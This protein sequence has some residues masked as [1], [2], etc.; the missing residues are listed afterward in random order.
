[1]SSVYILFSFAVTNVFSFPVLTEEFC[2]LML[3]ELGHFEQSDSPKGRP[4]TMNNH[5]VGTYIYYT[6]RT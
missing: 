3:E 2:H 4:N 6:I 5:G 1:M